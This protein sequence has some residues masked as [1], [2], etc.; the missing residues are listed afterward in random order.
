MRLLLCTLI[1]MSFRPLP[2]EFRGVT[3]QELAQR[4]DKV[5]SVKA[6]PLRSGKTRIGKSKKVR[7]LEAEVKRLNKLRSFNPSFGTQYG[8][9]ATFERFKGVID[10]NIIS[11]GQ[12]VDFK[13]DLKNSLKIPSDSYLSCRGT[14]L[15]SKYNYR[16][17]ASC[18]R[19]IT[20]NQ[21]YKVSV[22]IKDMNRV[23]GLK[24]DHVYTG[25][26][27]A[28][29]G[30]GFSAIMSGIID[31][32]KERVK[33]AVGFAEVPT[34]KNSILGGLVNAANMANQKAKDH[35]QNQVVVLAVKDK[36]EVVVEFK[37]RFNYE[38]N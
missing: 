36:T 27:E 30:E 9:I 6:A 18:D 15:A 32:R 33:T 28:V 13:V 37:R 20:P 21:E 22:G 38:K 25:D 34:L 12:P 23:D 16:I 1:L 19:L 24:P 3:K 26:E 2:K 11:S 8:S 5:K 17:I 7:R 10:G 29:L 35:T 31:A 4:I 14:N